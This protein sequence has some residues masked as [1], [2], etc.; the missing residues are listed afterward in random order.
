MLFRSIVAFPLLQAAMIAIVGIAF[1]SLLVLAGMA[2]INAY[3]LPVL[4]QGELAARLRPEHL[5]V[6]ALAALL[7]VGLPATAA[8][9]RA[10]RVEPSE[11]LREI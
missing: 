11:A 2:A 8:A 4:H 7:L 1:G 5:A 3:F 9:W 10:S 6:A